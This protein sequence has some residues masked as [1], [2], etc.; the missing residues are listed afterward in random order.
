MSGG[1]LFVC[2]GNICRSPL[3]E[4]IARREFARAGLRLPLASA[5]TGNWHV[6]EGADARARAVATAHGYTLEA[7]R[8]Q[9]VAVAHYHQYDWLLAMDRSNLAEIRQRA[10]TDATARCALLLDV[11][12]IAV[13]AEVPDPYFGG[14]AGFVDVLRLLERAVAGLTARIDRDG[15]RVEHG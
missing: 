8:A 14:E 5:G 6:G 9:Q 2:L 3:A 13:E 4:A 11:A 15:V 1:I 12:G 7:H 10:P